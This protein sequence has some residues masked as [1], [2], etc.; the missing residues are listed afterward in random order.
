M[1]TRA[2]LLQPYGVNGDKRSVF[3]CWDAETQEYIG[4]LGEFDHPARRYY[5]LVIG[6]RIKRHA[7]FGEA[8]R[9]MANQEQRT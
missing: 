7:T 3:T 9:R 1:R 2:L 4:M 6:G 8:W 5:S